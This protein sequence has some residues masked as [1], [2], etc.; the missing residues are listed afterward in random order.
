MIS[1]LKF[2]YE[3]IRAGA[4]PALSMVFVY[5]FLA[6]S[7]IPIGL[8]I[9]VW[10]WVAIWGRGEPPLL[11]LLQDMRQFV[12]T[13]FSTQVVAGIMAFVTMLVDDDADGKP[14]V[15]EADIKQK[16]GDNN[17]HG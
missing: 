2:I 9:G 3:K 4:M 6:A 17:V 5:V 13:M 12:G 7:L 16:G 1:K 10:S 11:A 14:D 8:Y 15:I